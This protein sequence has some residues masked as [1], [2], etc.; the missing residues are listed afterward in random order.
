MTLVFRFL[1][2]LLPIFLM[3]CATFSPSSMIK[4]KNREYLS[5][6]SI[7]PLRIPPGIASSTIQTYYPV[8]YKNYPPATLDVNLIPPGLMDR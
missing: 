3:S 1:M 7:P 8:S 2:L 5:A 4:S 6:E